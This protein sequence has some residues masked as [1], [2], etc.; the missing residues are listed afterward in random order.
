[1]IQ[2]KKHQLEKKNA[3]ILYFVNLCKR[4]LEKYFSFFDLL[5]IFSIHKRAI[6]A[7]LTSQM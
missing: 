4:K 6:Q 3:V 2:S 7:A 1:M 5:E